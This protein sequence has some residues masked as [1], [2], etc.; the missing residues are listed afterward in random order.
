VY[1]KI[2]LTPRNNTLMKIIFINIILILSTL[3]VHASGL[4]G[5]IL[6]TDSI[7]QW[8]LLGEP[9]NESNRLWKKVEAVLPSNRT[10]STS[11]WDGYTVFWSIKQNVLCLDSIQYELESFANNTSHTQN[12]SINADTLRHIFRKQFDG[13]NIVATWFTGKIRIARGK[14]IYYVNYGYRR[15]YEEEQIIDIKEGKI[16]E[17]QH[18]HNFIYKEGASFDNKKELADLIKNFP[19]D[20]KKYPELFEEQSNGERQLKT[21]RIYF[22]IKHASVDSIGHL[23]KCNVM[24]YIRRNNIT[25]ELPNIATEMEKLLKT[26]YPWRVTY[27]NG[28]YRAYGIEGFLLPYIIR[29]EP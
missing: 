16:Y 13:K 29:E 18:Y 3:T 26:Y 7:S 22:K 12:I 17:K 27:V 19:L 24:A 9:L 8:T 11:D 5:D 21:K 1:H 20:I 23:T 25:E 28:E 10:T 15:N 2:L 6:Y 14:L 4:A